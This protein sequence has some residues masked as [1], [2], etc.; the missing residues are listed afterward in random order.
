MARRSSARATDGLGEVQ[1]YLAQAPSDKLDLSFGIPTRRAETVGVPVQSAFKVQ[2]DGVV[3]TRDA[4]LP[5]LTGTEKFTITL[6]KAGGGA[7]DTSRTVEISITSVAGSPAM[8]WF[9]NSIIGSTWGCRGISLFRLV[10]LWFAGAQVRTG[11]LTAQLYSLVGTTSIRSMSMKR[12]QLSIMAF[13][14]ALY[15]ASSPTAS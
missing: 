6:T 7:S 2:G 1:T 10:W 4:A 15:L 14:L 3:A 8:D 13:R 11:Q 12:A 5:G 9:S